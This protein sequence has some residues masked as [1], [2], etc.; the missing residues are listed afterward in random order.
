MTN[1]EKCDGF[2]IGDRIE[3]IKPVESEDIKIG[4]TG[5]ITN[6][7][8]CY[9]V[10]GMEFFINMDK[11]INQIHIVEKHSWREMEFVYEDGFGT[12]LCSNCIDFIKKI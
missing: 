5:I 6:I 4:D 3:F 10:E 12:W 7:M 1:R 8:R 2:C 11:K 9:H